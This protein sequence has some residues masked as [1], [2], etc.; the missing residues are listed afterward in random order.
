MPGQ[1]TLKKIEQQIVRLPIND[2]LK[3]IARISELL[4][5][6]Q[7]ERIMAVEEQKSLMQQREKEAD[8]LLAICDAAAEQWVGD[9]DSSQDIRQIRQ[10]RVEQIWQNR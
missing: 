8:R 10:E 6:A 3:L 7:I 5:M 1:T 4:S 9:F 2:Q